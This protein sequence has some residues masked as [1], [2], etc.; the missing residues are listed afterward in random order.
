MAYLSTPH[1]LLGH[2]RHAN[3]TLDIETDFNA[4]LKPIKHKDGHVSEIFPK[5]LRELF[6]YDG[7]HRRP[8]MD[9]MMGGDNLQAEQLVWL[10]REYGLHPLERHSENLNR[11]LIFLG[12]PRSTQH[13]LK[14]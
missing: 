4:K 2:S 14:R 5:T 3:S 6:S 9:L 13:Q 7:K 11:F 10:I 8:V 1:A 12:E